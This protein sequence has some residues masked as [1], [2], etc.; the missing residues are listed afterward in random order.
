ME[1]L[2][3][4]TR[5]AGP[6]RQREGGV[7]R[8]GL[9]EAPPLPE[10]PLLLHGD[11]VLTP[12]EH[13]SE[14]GRLGSRRRV[15]QDGR[16]AGRAGTPLG[17]LLG[18]PC[19]SPV[20]ERSRGWGP[21][22]PAWAE[23]PR[24]GWEPTGLMGALPKEDAPPHTRCTHH[25]RHQCTHHRQETCTPHPWLDPGRVSCPVFPGR[26]LGDK[27]MPLDRSLQSPSAR[28][29]VLDTQK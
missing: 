1:T 29:C 4:V 12:A 28:L 7:G 16:R 26:G 22:T 21:G 20:Q 6:P 25:T 19:A 24:D 2:C 10:A 27:A 14:S 3:P 17:R 13:S 23:D 5:A 15:L 9:G 8:R 11:M 18:L